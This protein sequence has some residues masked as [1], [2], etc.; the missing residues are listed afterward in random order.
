MSRVDEWGPSSLSIGASQISSQ[1]GYSGTRRAHFRGRQQIDKDY[2]AL[3]GGTLFLDEV[4]ELP[5]EVQANLLRVCEAKEVR[6]VGSDVFKVDVRL[7]SA[8]LAPL[9]ARVK[10]GDFR[11]AL[12]ARLRSIITLP[13][14]RSRR[15]GNLG[16]VSRFPWSPRFGLTVAKRLLL[17]DWVENVRGLKGAAEHALLFAQLR[18]LKTSDLPEMRMSVAA[19]PGRRW[20]E[21]MRVRRVVTITHGNRW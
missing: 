3:Q 14:L 1:A 10:S 21:T 9:E 20:M 11:A 13:P 15:D 17:N 7:V 8:T 2:F 6:P 5:L 19:T 16:A 18:S 4:A 12:L